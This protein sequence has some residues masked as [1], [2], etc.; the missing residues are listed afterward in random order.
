MSFAM[1]VVVVLLTTSPAHA[2][3]YGEDNR[4]EPSSSH[5]PVV[6][7]ANQATATM[8]RRDRLRL[9]RDGDFELTQLDMKKRGDFCAS[10]TYAEQASHGTC[11]GVLIS[12]NIILTAGHCMPEESICRDYVWVFG[13]EQGSEPWHEARRVRADQVYSCQGVI[14]QLDNGDISSDMF[15]MMGFTVDHYDYALIQ[16]ERPVTCARPAKFADPD[17]ALEGRSVFTISNPFGMLK[18]LSAN[19]RIFAP[20]DH[21]NASE[22]NLSMLVF[23]SFFI[24]NLDIGPGSSGSPIFDSKSGKIVG[25]ISSGPNSDTERVYEDNGQFWERSKWCEKELHL[26]DD[27]SEGVG[28]VAF[29]TSYLPIHENPNW[30]TAPVKTMASA[31]FADFKAGFSEGTTI[32]PK[33]APDTEIYCL[34]STAAGLFTTNEFMITEQGPKWNKRIVSGSRKLRTDIQGNIFFRPNRRTIFY[35]PIRAEERSEL[36]DTTWPVEML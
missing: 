6:L 9:R 8:I 23:N 7:E 35:C 17:L 33:S 5:D 31:R 20:E 18:K 29:R 11:G 25:L 10:E 21:K 24:T 30:K 15:R 26:K 2:I 13:Y 27:F 22:F 3:I 4:V 34:Q 1:L 14:D 19:A 16:L 12:K 32:L 28:T 36:F